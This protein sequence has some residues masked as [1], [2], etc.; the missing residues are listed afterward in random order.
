MTVVDAT[1][2]A[3]PGTPVPAAPAVRFVGDRS[4][5]WRLLIRGAVLLAVTLGI[6]RF[7]FATDVRRFLWSNTEIAGETL[8]YTG[9]AVRAADRLPD[10]DRAA[11]PALCRVFRG[12]AEPR[13]GRP[14]HQRA[15]LSAAGLPRPVRGLPRPPLSPHP[16][17]LSRRALPSGRLGAALRGL[18]AVLVDADRAHARPRLSVRAVA[19]RALQDAAHLLRQS[20]GPLRGLGPCGCSC[21]ACRCG[22]W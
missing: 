13:P 18:R 3:A 1:A 7:W 14:A 10:R 16:H 17:H 8:E 12:R 5:Y 20:A 21:A 2:A 4:A 9:T 15:R 11:G 19:P 22:S 6:Y